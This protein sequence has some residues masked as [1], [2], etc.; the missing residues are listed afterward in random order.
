MSALVFSTKAWLLA[1]ITD[2]K[3]DLHIAPASGKSC[4][5]VPKAVIVQAY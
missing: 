1:V 3:I 2:K 5:V 4:L